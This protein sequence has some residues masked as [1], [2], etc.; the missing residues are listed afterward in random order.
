M[1]LEGIWQ[2]LTINVDL[3]KFVSTQLLFSGLSSNSMIYSSR[4][5]QGWAILKL[6]RCRFCL[7]GRFSEPQRQREG[8]Q[9]ATMRADG[10]ISGNWLTTILLYPFLPDT[11]A[12]IL[13]RLLT[14]FV[15]LTNM[16]RCFLHSLQPRDNFGKEYAASNFIS[17]WYRDDP[18]MDFILL[19]RW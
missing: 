9:R 15:Q 2:L 17:L 19:N 13:L 18:F 16:V 12:V 6:A 1:W 4:D 11:S 8:R 10:I 3:N 5:K 7:L 14:C